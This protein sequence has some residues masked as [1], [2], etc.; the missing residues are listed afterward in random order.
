MD[1][2]HIHSYKQDYIYWTGYMLEHIYASYTY[3]HKHTVI[4]NGKR[5]H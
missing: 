1:L 3:I 2:T 5:C 4:T